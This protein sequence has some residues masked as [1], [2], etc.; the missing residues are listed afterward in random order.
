MYINTRDTR[1]FYYFLCDDSPYLHRRLTSMN[2]QDYRLPLSKY[3]KNIYMIIYWTTSLLFIIFSYEIYIS[4]I[5]RIEIDSQSSTSVLYINTR[6]TRSFYHFLYGDSWYLSTSLDYTHDFRLSL[7][8]YECN[9]QY[10]KMQVRL[11]IEL[12]RYVS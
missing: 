3:K 2:L 4:S 7:S 1:S 8:K 5:D 6:D 12:L 10:K 11:F 9:M